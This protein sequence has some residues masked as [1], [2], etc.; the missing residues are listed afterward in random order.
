VVA[1]GPLEAEERVDDEAALGLVGEFEPVVDGRGRVGV[2]EHL[3]ARVRALVS[4]QL[5]AEVKPAHP[6]L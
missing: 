5:E 1:D 6:T 4:S 2:V 3:K